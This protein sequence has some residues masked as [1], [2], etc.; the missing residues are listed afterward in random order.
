MFLPC[1]GAEGYGKASQNAGT[2]IQVAS[3]GRKGKYTYLKAFSYTDGG[4]SHTLTM[5]KSVS[6]TTLT[7]AA[8]AA[9]ADVVL[10]A[11]PGTTSTGA[12]AANDLV[13]IKKPNGDWHFGKV[14]SWTAGTLT[15]TLTAN[16]PTGGFASG[17]RVL[18]YGAPSDS[19]H[20]NF[21]FASLATSSIKNFPPVEK[22]GILMKSRTTDEPI[23]LDSNNASNAGTIEFHEYVF[24][25]VG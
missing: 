16:V 22:G 2:R 1:E 25:R 11:D 23:I 13:C 17:A 4:T 8:V 12:I 19:D 7:A 9:Q 14:S 10:A 15:L 21:Q 6:E 18:F 5:M 3:Q 24:S 20:A